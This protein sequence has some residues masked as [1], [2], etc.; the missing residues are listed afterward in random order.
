MTVRNLDKLFRPTSVAVVG[1]SDD[2]RKLGYVMMRNLLGARPAGPVLPVHPTRPSVGGVLAYPTIESLPVVPELAVI[3]TPARTVP[4]LVDSLAKRGTRAAIVLADYMDEPADDTGRTLR[5]AM[6]DAARP[7]RMRI[8]GPGSIGIM[9]PG[10]SLNASL[11]H[12]PPDA[13]RIAFVSQSRAM[14]AAVLDWAEARGIGFS[15]IVSVGSCGDVDVSDVLDVLAVEP[16]VS[17]ILL[18]LASVGDARKF[19]SAGRAA[20]RTKRVI[21]L[22]G[23]TTSE[24]SHG[25]A[26]RAELAAQELVYDAA[27]R[28]AGMLQVRG[29][30][31]LFDA[32]E[33]LARARRVLRGDRLAVVANGRG[34]AMLALERLIVEGGEPAVLDPNTVTQLSRIIPGAY[35][36][37]NPINLTATASG[38]P[39][40]D[41]IKTV[42]GDPNIDALLVIHA[43]VELAD[44]VDTARGVVDATTKSP[45]TV[46]TSWMG[47]RSAAQGREL[48]AQAGIPTYDTPAQAVRAFMHIVKYQHS[49]EML[50]EMPSS[51]PAEFTRDTARARQVVETALRDG[52]NKLT[53]PEAKELLAA[54]GV[55]VVPA[56]LV[57]DASSATRRAKEL[58]FPVALKVLSPDIPRKSDVGAVALDLESEQEV[59]DAMAS[60]TRRV[61]RHR[62]DARIVGYSIERMVRRLEAT[63]L[64]VGVQSHP[65]FGP[66]IVFGEGG[67]RAAVGNDRAV[68]L[69]PLNLELARRL[70][71]RTRIFRLLQGFGSV[72]PVDLDAVGI[73]L[74]R[75]S[76]LVIDVP[77]LQELLIDPLSA[78]PD[79]VMVLDASALL[80]NAV[81]PGTR[82][83]AIRPYPSE[84]EETQTVLGKGSWLLRP[85]RP[86]DEASHYRFFSM[87]TAED[88]EL[89]FFNPIRELS[90]E[91]M[92]RLTQIDYDREMAFIAQALPAEGSR[93][94]D[95]VQ[96]GDTLGVVRCVFDADG[97]DGE[98]AISVRSDQKGKGVG[99]MLMEKMISYARA[100]GARTMSGEV[101]PEN[102]RML[103]L[104]Q[105]LGFVAQRGDDPRVV[106]IRLDL[107]GAVNLSPAGE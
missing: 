52:R 39:Y 96:P 66:L 89:R 5:Q 68:A 31:E 43:P 55:P 81:Q 28:R 79:G 106:R 92:A 38:E 75:V 40:S 44:A 95:G 32:V 107:A 99:R 58:G 23:A 91:A 103:R 82:R 47:E 104:A 37:G 76:Q 57:H 70:M 87:L 83:L 8:L 84:L 101:L 78:G 13:G 90:R 69:P 93:P 48:F 26:D 86:E 73:T 17:A 45:C 62:P 4:G 53:E 85:I 25:T 98:F 22:R 67:A 18:Y 20:A 72:L 102:S 21:V 27:F 100:R 97:Q 12:Q 2:P 63:E 33:T 61:G 6:L 30:D 94:S 105:S 7:H 1:A 71:R 24:P 9:V 80:S 88:R 16:G 59:V 42:S 56:F 60:V 51:A 36:Q 46:L 64:L 34:P 50:L 15:H 35:P 77:E 3:T 49:Q 11:M 14:C 54:Y 29:V 65:V 41:V 19:L 10:Q 74:L